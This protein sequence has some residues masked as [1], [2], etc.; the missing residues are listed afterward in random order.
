MHFHLILSIKGIQR[1]PPNLLFID[2]DKNDFETITA[3]KLALF[4]TLK[5]I[6]EKLNGFP[7]VLWLGNGYHIIQPVSCP[8]ILVD[9]ILETAMLENITEFRKYDK[10]SQE[11]LRFAKD[12]LSNGKADK[13][14]KPSFKSCLIRIPNSINSKSNITT[15]V[16]IV[17]KWNGNCQVMNFEY[18]IS[19][20]VNSRRQIRSPLTK[21]L[22][23][24][25]K[26]Y[27]IHKKIDQDIQ[28]Q[29]I[30]VERSK[31]KFVDSSNYYSWI[32]N[33]IQI[34]I[35]DFRKLVIDIILAPY[36]INVK[37]LS[38]LEESYQIIKNWLDKCNELEP[39]D[40]YR[41]FEYRINYALKIALNKGI[42]PM[43]KDTIKTDPKYSEL[44]QLLKESKV[45]S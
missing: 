18:K 36:L 25:F 9:G 5:N 14:N 21:E 4:N 1:Y 41:N 23:L 29:K 30:L 28:R 17:Q 6:K 24:D 38:N 10:P 43:N 34:P 35:E 39:L 44:H 40:N 20:V 19:M 26:R 22:M 15:K 33:L 12:Y 7:T 13:N 32:E 3:L 45:L 37:Q 27:L 16:R 8:K 42:P 2:L 11:F 31:N